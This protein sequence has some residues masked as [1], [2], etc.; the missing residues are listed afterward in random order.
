VARSGPRAIAATSEEG[1]DGGGAGSFRP[2]GVRRGRGAG[3]L[4]DG[5]NAGLRS[6]R[7]AAGDLA[8]ARFRLTDADDLTAANDVQTDR[9]RIYVSR[10]DMFGWL[11][12]RGAGWTGVVAI[13]VVDGKAAI[14]RRLADGLRGAD[15]I[16]LHPDGKHLILSDYWGRRLRFVPIDGQPGGEATA[17]LEI[18]PDNLTLDGERLLIASQENGFFA[19]INL[20]I[21]SAPSPSA[22]YA[23]DVRQL[24]AY[25]NPRL[26][27]RGGWSTGRSV[28]VAVPVPGAVAMG[29]I[30][31][32]SVLVVQCGRPSSGMDLGLTSG[33]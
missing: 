7:R 22:V 3:R 20:L 2:A 23:I 27:W 6:G 15:G 9:E 16:V 1:A 11:P 4:R 8:P 28:S 10:F 24:G 17:E 21:A 30:P 31:A 18:H 25:A 12:W 33:L 5:R 13:Q 26:V 19:A 14:E 29:Q 32:P